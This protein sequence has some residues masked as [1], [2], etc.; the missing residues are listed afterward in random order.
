MSA[1]NP[2]G[3]TLYVA[4][5]LDEVEF[6]PRDEDDARRHRVFGP[7][8]TFEAAKDR[9]QFLSTDP[10]EGVVVELVPGWAGEHVVVLTDDERQELLHAIRGADE[11]YGD[12]DHPARSAMRKLRSSDG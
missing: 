10:N 5:L 2:E 4:G 1:R 6:G 9:A 11:A 7:F 3:A 12:P 8:T